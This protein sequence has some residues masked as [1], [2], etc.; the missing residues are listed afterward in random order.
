MEDSDIETNYCDW[1]RQMYVNVTL[2]KQPSFFADDKSI[3]IRCIYGHVPSP[4]SW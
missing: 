1:M 3:Q 2:Q 4:V